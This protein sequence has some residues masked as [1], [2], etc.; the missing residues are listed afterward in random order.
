[1]AYTIFGNFPVL[2]PGLTETTS[3]NGVKFSNGTIAYIPSEKDAALKLAETYGSLF[4]PPTTK[5]TGQGFWELSFQA[6]DIT[7]DTNKVI[8]SELVAVTKHFG[9]YVIVEKWR[10]TTLTEYTALDSDELG[11]VLPNRISNFKFSKTMENR[12]IFGIRPTS[13]PSALNITWLTEIRS[14][15]RRNFGN[16]D[17]ADIVYG[18]KYKIS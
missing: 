16:V 7:A 1:M 3:R 9:A 17:E 14:I 8:G 12:E 2:L 6:L 4:P 5:N 13:E 15:T 18:L 11:E 10:L